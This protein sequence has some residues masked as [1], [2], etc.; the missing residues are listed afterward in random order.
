MMLPLSKTETI[1][2]KTKQ[3]DPKRVNF[4]NFEKQKNVFLSHVPKNPS[5]QKLGSE[6]KRCALQLGHRQTDMRV[7]TE[8]TLSGFRIFFKV[9]Q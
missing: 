5:V 6:V 8:D 9:F 3:N 1:R 4:Q 2:E 7:K